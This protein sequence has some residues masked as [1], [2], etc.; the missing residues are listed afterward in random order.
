MVLVEQWHAH[1]DAINY[2]TWVP[3][4]K[5]VASCSFDCNV[6][7][8]GAS[9]YTNNMEK[10]GSLILGNRA[11]DPNK[12]E[13]K[14]RRNAYKWLVNIDKVTR[15]KDELRE[16]QSLLREVDSI[17]YEKMKEEAEAR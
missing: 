14:P 12:K 8:W 3:D 11:D 6:Y 5:I 1:K 13:A 7:I 16:A 15:F 17:D 2:V 9:E 4:L 10:K